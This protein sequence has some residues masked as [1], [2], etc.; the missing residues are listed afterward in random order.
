MLK[1]VPYSKSE[2]HFRE[3]R[4]NSG[5]AGGRVLGSSIRHE[6]EQQRKIRLPIV[7][8]TLIA[9]FIYVSLWRRKK[10]I[11][12]KINISKHK[13]FFSHLI[14]LLKRTHSCESFL[15]NWHKRPRYC[16][17]VSAL[18]GDDIHMEFR[19]DQNRKWNL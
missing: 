17:L 15:L 1:R 7:R 4:P 2:F 18:F 13:W 12:A 19:I 8:T 5:G 11:Q 10:P 16:I 6:R 9:R 3:P 14:L